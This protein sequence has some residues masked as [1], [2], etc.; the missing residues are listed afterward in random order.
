MI[1]E[2][3]DRTALVT[4]ASRGIGAATAMALARAGCARVLV[5]YNSNSEGAERAAEEIGLLGAEAVVL[6][7][8]LSNEAGIRAFTEV[9]EGQPGTID[10]LVN[11][12]GSLVKRAK[13]AECT[14]ELFDEVMDLNVK[15]MFFLT[16]AVANRMAERGGAIVNISSIAARTGGGSGAAVYAA[17]KAAVSALTKGLAKELAPSGIR[18]NAVSPGTVD[19]DFHARFSTREMLA[20]VAATTPQ[21]RL[22]TNEEMADVI[23]FLLSE[24]ARN[25]IG[26]T[27]E[28][29]GGAYLV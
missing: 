17:A 14:Y 25:I 24:A 3:K 6:Q 27:I 5:H 7:G 9:L 21:G 26:Q 11:N 23:V 15:S 8:D 2:F 4:G 18:V 16:Q 1:H 13:L 28:V 12:A 22:S 20:S 29:N 19:N 10:F